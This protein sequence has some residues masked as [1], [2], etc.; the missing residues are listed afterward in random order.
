MSKTELYKI[1][2]EHNKC[3][4]YVKNWDK[5]QNII[6][7]IT[8]QVRE[9]NE[10]HPN[11]TVLVTIEGNTLEISNGQIVRLPIP[12]KTGG[13]EVKS[14]YINCAG[15]RIEKSDIDSFDLEIKS[16]T[17]KNG[18]VIKYTNNFLCN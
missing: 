6:D 9:F 14:T 2:S 1:L 3:T 13:I 15:V 11:D 8:N 16:F 7:D 4:Y 18:S 12:P 5:R 10:K 17:T